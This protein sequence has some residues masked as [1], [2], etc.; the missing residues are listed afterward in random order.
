MNRGQTLVGLSLVVALA[1]PL[2][3]CAG[4]VKMTTQKMCQAHGG[5]YNAQTK[6]CTYSTQPLSAEQI[7]EGQGGY[8]D[9]AA[10]S[11]VIGM[12]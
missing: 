3:G 5:K 12:Q 11:C 7:C 6:R 4:S 10:D 2:S 8:Y 1:V 9:T